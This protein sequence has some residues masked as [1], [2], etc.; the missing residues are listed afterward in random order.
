MDSMT[1]L[2]MTYE[3]FSGLYS[4]P[5]EADN[6]DRPIGIVN[7]YGIWPQVYDSSAPPGGQRT[8][9]PHPLCSAP[10]LYVKEW[11]FGLL[12]KGFWPLFYMFLGAQVWFGVSA[13]GHDMSVNTLI[14]NDLHHGSHAS[15]RPMMLLF[16]P[17]PSSP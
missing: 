14:A 16:P 15:A 3:S 11:R 8:T 17:V 2:N 13:S 4:G 5:Y 7:G 1:I 9:E 10:I 6:V 12:L